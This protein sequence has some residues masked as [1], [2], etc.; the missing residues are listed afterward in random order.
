[1]SGVF[2]GIG[3]MPTSWVDRVEDSERLRDL[4]AGIRKATTSFTEEADQSN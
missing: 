4:A 2:N 3:K 1:L